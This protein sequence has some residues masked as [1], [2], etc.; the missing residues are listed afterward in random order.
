MRSTSLI[1]AALL[2]GAAVAA[3]ETYTIDPRHT[4]PSFEV[5]HLGFSTQR[6]RFNST[7]GTIVLDRAAR[8]A[9]V[10]V[11]I[12][13]RSINTGLDKLD[14]YP[15]INFKSTHARFEG[16]KLVALDGDLTMRGV[17]RPVTLTMSSF[18]CGMHPI[19]KKPAC[20]ADAMTMI[21]R[22]DYGINYALPAVGDDVKL[23]IQVEAHKQ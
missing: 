15:K 22:S 7:S 19:L 11:S 18:Y 13:V 2:A 12:D 23:L 1:I 9:S 4:F 16:D 10:E 8:S 21:K 5:N 14:K 6:G 17:T 3:P 20:G